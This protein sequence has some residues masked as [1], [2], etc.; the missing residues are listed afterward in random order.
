MK[1]GFCRTSAIKLDAF[2]DKSQRLCPV[3]LCQRRQQPH[4]LPRR[5]H[6]PHK[7]LSTTA[8]KHVGV[9]FGVVNYSYAF[10]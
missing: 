2:Y 1:C 4:T 7:A 9:Q 6:C 8:H 5:G 10:S 3:H